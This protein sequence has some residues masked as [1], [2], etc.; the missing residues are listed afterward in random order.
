MRSRVRI[1]GEQRGKEKMSWLFLEQMDSKQVPMGSMDFV[2]VSI[3]FYAKT[4]L[5]HPNLGGA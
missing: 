2:G 1:K 3:F 5:K 4:G